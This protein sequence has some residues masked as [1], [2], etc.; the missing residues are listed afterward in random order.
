[1]F[2]VLKK[3]SVKQTVAIAAILI[4][5]GLNLANPFKAQATQSNLFYLYP[6]PSNNPS[7]T[8]LFW[9]EANPKM[10]AFS[11]DMW[12]NIIPDKQ[13]VIGLPDGYQINMSVLGKKGGY[14][15]NKAE[16]ITAKIRNFAK[17]K[18]TNPS[19][20]NSGNGGKDILTY[21]REIT[22]QG[23]IKEKVRVE[24]IDHFKNNDNF[25][26]YMEVI[27]GNL[28]DVNELPDDNVKQIPTSTD[29]TTHAITMFGNTLILSGTA[30]LLLK[31]LPLLI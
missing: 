9:S 2:I 29:D 26:K 18:A 12:K 23:G 27:K 10:G 20:G 28:V 31:L 17:G 13:L 19:I 6:Y 11:L 24:I 30:L 14:I 22:P 7:Q 3:S 16:A 25:E 5:I 21:E 15:D 1:M 4:I 8:V